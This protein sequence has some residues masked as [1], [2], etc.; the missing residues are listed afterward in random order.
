MVRACA[1]GPTMLRPGMWNRL[2][3]ASIVASFDR[4]GYERH[5]KEFIPGELDVDL[6]GK[7]AL[8]TGATAGIGLAAATALAK[9]G[10]QVWLLARDAG[11]GEASCDAIVAAGARVRPKVIMC[12]IA[13]LASVRAAAAAWCGEPI[14]VLV[15]NAGLMP[16]TRIETSDGLELCWATH[17]AGPHL[18]TTLLA[19]FL[20]HANGARVIWVSSGGMYFKKLRLDDTQWQAR[21]YNGT[22][23]YAE[24]KRAQQVLAELWAEKLKASSTT[25]VHCMHPG[26]VDTA[27]VRDAMPGFYRR[28]HA[29]LRTPAQGADTIV[30]LAASARAATSSG[31]FWFDRVARSPYLLPFTRESAADRAALWAS[32]SP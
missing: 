20:A 17:V 32:A 14:D 6:T 27:G 1:A 12:D 8:V 22:N 2:L 25:V 15:H 16:S 21:P 31:K 7:H 10:A 18:L 9:L 29:N 4:R 23:A 5:A 30:W 19:P 26:W 13:S 3:D 24:T 28:M 11:R